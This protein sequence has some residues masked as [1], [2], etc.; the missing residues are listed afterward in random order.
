MFLW[1]GASEGLVDPEPLDIE[2][3]AVVS[4]R[5]KTRKVATKQKRANAV[6][7]VDEPGLNFL[8]NEPFTDRY[9]EIKKV[10]DTYPMN[11]PA[12]VATLMK[13]IDKNQVTLLTAATGS[14]KTTSIGR[15]VIQYLERLYGNTSKLLITQPRQAPARFIAERVAD[16]LDVPI[17]QQV[18][19]V[20]KN[21][22]MTSSATRV[23]F[24][25]EGILIR[26]FMS[27][28]TV[29]EYKAI[30]IDEAHERTI[31]TDL[32]LLFLKQLVLSGA[33]P[34]LRIIIMSATADI[35]T[36][37]NYFKPV[38]PTGIVEIGGR[39]F[40]VE[41]H[42]HNANPVEYVPVAVER[43][44]KICNSKK[45]PNG[46]IL[47]FFSGKR[48]L[49]EACEILDTKK[50]TLKQKVRCFEFSSDLDSKEQDAIA[51]QPASY[52]GVD[53]KVIMATNVAE[54]SI[55]IDGIVF[56]IDSGRA[57]VSGFDEK[58]GHKTLD[59]AWV[60]KAAIRQRIGRAGRT[61]PGIAYCLY[62]A[63][64]FGEL[65]DF[66]TPAI[67]REE[68]TDY[69][70]RLL[71]MPHFD[72][73]PKLRKVMDEMI[74]P[75]KPASLDIA[76][77][78][79][80]LLGA[81]DRSETLSKLGKQMS[82][83]PVGVELARAI[84]FSSSYGVSREILR[85]AAMISTSGAK[86]EDFFFTSHIPTH[87]QDPAGELCSI[88]RILEQ[89]QE[90][91]GEEL[92][93]YCQDNGIIV[94]YVREARKTYGR[95]K[96]KLDSAFPERPRY[97]EGKSLV[98]DVPAFSKTWLTTQ[99]TGTVTERIIK[100]LLHGFFRNVVMKREDAF[101]AIGTDSKVR[102]KN[103]AKHVTMATYVDILRINK[104]FSAS[105]ITPIPDPVWF[106]DA[107]QHYLPEIHKRHQIETLRE[108]ERR[109]RIEVGES[110]DKKSEM[111]SRRPDM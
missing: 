34:D 47:V 16:E 72:T 30:I 9:Y 51:K 88:L 60:S 81:L 71:T 90:L 57:N 14:G 82:S 31:E 92:D 95:L 50:R 41:V 85:I 103:V 26:I 55:T 29:P 20:Y 63:D 69:C 54:A 58:T 35:A 5:K 65:D 33:R 32:I 80:G 59:T 19:Y 43:V 6:S 21:I 24:M 28:F 53:R 109:R 10:T 49:K 12:N 94:R 91:T 37:A 7:A 93:V 62:T 68:L 36:F 38:T 39:T 45:L 46:D 101:Y 106:L 107:A 56:V 23:T 18:G 25:T 104:R 108:A 86:F 77:R 97:V 48:D 66:S 2:S 42:Y 100:C 89:T 52:F 96:F 111:F 17:R 102:C 75:P 87:Y 27:D 83:F 1:G 99:V 76:A 110:L 61:R 8:T 40:P 67:R 84:L 44:L 105:G 15:H 22:N 64:K 3:E 79:L 78:H 70:L 74:T 13:S 4:R 11:Q 98:V 73:M